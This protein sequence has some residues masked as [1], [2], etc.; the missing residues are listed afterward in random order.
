M[1]H[2]RRKLCSILTCLCV[3]VIKYTVRPAAHILFSRTD[4]SLA[5]NLYFIV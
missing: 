5:T 1:P 4:Y 3:I 2:P